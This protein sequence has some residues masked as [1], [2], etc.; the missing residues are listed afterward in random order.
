MKLGVT[1]NFGQMGTEMPI[2]GNAAANPYGIAPATSAAPTDSVLSM[3]GPQDSAAS[4]TGYQPMAGR[5][6]RLSANIV[7][8]SS[9]RVADGG[10]GNPNPAYS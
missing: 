10:Y 7:G 8:S 4:G 2:G 6:D 3:Q 5:A 9:D 1:P